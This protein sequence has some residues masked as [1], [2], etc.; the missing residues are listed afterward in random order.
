M[1][2]CIFFTAA[3]AKAYEYDANDFAT[4]VV[5]Y[6]EGNASEYDWI[7]G[8][9][10][11]NP[12]NSLGR[13]TVDTT[14][15]NWKIPVS[16][17]VPV[18]NV[19][20]A[21]RSFE[22]VTV[23]DGGRLILRFNNPVRDDENNLYGIDLIVFGNAQQETG[24]GLFWENKD[25]STFWVN[26]SELIADEA[27]VSVS[28]DGV[29]WYSYTNGPYADSFAPTFGRVYDPNNP[30]QSI[31]SW[32]LWWGQATDPTQPL[33]PALTA[34]N[35]VGKTVAQISQMYG[36]SAGG[37][38]FDLGE[39]GMEW[40]QYVKIVGRNG[41]TPE[42]DA[43]ADVSSCGDW[44][45]PYPAGDVTHDCRVN[46]EDLAMLAGYW[47]DTMMGPENPAA[48]ADIYSD[49][50]INFKDWTVMADG[51]LECTWQCE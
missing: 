28:Q 18:V 29:N 34:A 13:P 37:T 49:N 4:E 46:Y 38:G 47:L 41:N 6:V 35:F 50:I 36:E 19:Y 23:G 25:P 32:N 10:F 3:T 11:D 21:F 42:V 48:V 45:H 1:L 15:E 30:D 22:L 33:N 44:K 26:S 14:G 51:W 12:A 7:S 20:G 17:K 27:I 24:T 43:V 40:I 2:I 16:T 9:P 5:E 39:S 8:L 31:G